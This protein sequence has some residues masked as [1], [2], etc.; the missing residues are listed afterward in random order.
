MTSDIENVQSEQAVEV[1]PSTDKL[2]ARLISDAEAKAGSI[3]SEAEAKAKAVI[4]SADDAKKS[5]LADT[6]KK[7]EAE[8]EELTRRRLSKADLDGKKDALSAKQKLVSKVY[9]DAIEAIKGSKSYP[10]LLTA[11]IEK[12]AANG[13]E[14]Q[15]ALAD[16]D[17]D[18]AKIV[19]V[20]ADKK[21]I[22]LTLAKDFGA[23]C[24]GVMIKGKDYDKNLTLEVEIAA[25]RET[26]EAAIVKE[27]FN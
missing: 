10:Q 27:L 12:E 9:D 11:M 3:I 1:K 18:H 7:G 21:K 8:G 2:V 14:I 16:K 17:L 4:A 23:F 13:D 6:K 26:G 22:K 24:G 15:F 5:L 19:K 25:L 20:A